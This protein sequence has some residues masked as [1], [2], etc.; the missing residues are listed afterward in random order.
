MASNLDFELI[1]PTKDFLYSGEFWSR[2][3]MSRNSE[4]SYLKKLVGLSQKDK[5]NIIMLIKDRV[6]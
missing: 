4:G 6:C 5:T 2:L 1:K 3:K